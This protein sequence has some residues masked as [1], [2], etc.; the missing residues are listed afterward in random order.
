MKKIFIA[1]MIAALVH[2]GPLLIEQGAM[3]CNML[4]ENL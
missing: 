2:G 3:F 4:G 1:A